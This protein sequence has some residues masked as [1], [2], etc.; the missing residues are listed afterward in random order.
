MA[1]AHVQ[2]QTLE[3]RLV[4][5]SIAGTWAVWAVG[6]LYVLAPALG[7]IL[8][9]IWLARYTGVLAGPPPPARAVPTGAVLWIAAMGVMAIGLVVGHVDFGLGL[10]QTVKSFIGWMKGWALMAVFIFVGAIMRV[11]PEVVYRATGHVA[12]HTL[13][14]TPVFVAAAY[15]GLPGK[16]FVSPLQ[17]VGGPGPE[18]FAVELYGIEPETGRPR[19]RF[20]SPWAPAAAFV[21]CIGF[22]FALQE[23][24]RFW[25]FIGL[26]ATAVVCLLSQSRLGMLAVPVV[27]VSVVVLSS[28]TRPFVYAAGA[29]ATIL[30]LPIVGTLMEL[31][32]DAIARFKGARASSSRVRSTLQSIALHRWWGEAPIWGHGIVE[33]GP[34]LVEYMPIGSHHSWN[35]LLYVKGAVGLLSLAIPMLWTLCEMVA[36]AQCDRVARAGLGVMLVLLLYSFGENLEILVYLFWPG[37]IVVG[38]ATRRR[39]VSPFHGFLGRWRAAAA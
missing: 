35:G 39:L 22:V 18:F 6:G 38:V 4:Y 10:A 8:V 24:S 11:R 3:E 7:W 36:K 25:K 26:A 13:L 16:L 15:S 32:E 17:I 31:V 33:K 14:L 12:L 19:W 21:A 27:A 2:P 9:A 29:L 1:S 23:R 34:H 20:F 37:L 5:W 30:A 28:L